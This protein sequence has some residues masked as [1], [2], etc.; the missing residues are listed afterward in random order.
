MKFALTKRNLFFIALMSFYASCGREDIFDHQRDLVSLTSHELNHPENSQ[1][2]G[3]ES[4]FSL[5]LAGCFGVA[6]ACGG[7]GHVLVEMT[8]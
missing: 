7:W 6:A 5:K 1:G 2:K 8:A 3:N 4:N